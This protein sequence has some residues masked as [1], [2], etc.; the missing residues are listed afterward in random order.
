MSKKP[1]T[2]LALSL[3]DYPVKHVCPCCG[4]VRKRRMPY[5]GGQWCLRCVE[6][7]EAGEVWWAS[8]G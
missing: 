7:A 3:G 1:W 5:K 4:K 2:Q 6:K 8:R